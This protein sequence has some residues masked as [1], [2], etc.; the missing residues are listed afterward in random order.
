MEAYIRDLLSKEYP[1]LAHSELCPQCRKP[2]MMNISIS[3][4]EVT[5]D[6]GNAQTLVTETF[7]CAVC[8]I[9]VRSLERPQENEEE[10]KTPD[11][12]SV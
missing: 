8:H 7:H 3:R 1:M 10:A 4:R 9:F 6:S 2:R 11:C 12:S 5:D